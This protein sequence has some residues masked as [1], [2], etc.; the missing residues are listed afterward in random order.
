MAQA[1]QLQA[2]LA[3]AGEALNKVPRSDSNMR[4]GSQDTSPQGSPPLSPRRSSAPAGGRKPVTTTKPAV[5][6]RSPPPNED[7]EYTNIRRPL[8]SIFDEPPEEKD[9]DEDSNALDDFDV[10]DQRIASMPVSY[11]HLTLPTNR[12]V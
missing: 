2:E 7:D 5:S 11:T 9:S 1:K 3:K 12:E 4:P 10:D 8:N 6:P